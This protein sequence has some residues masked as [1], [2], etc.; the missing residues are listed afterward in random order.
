M[1]PPP[2]LSILVATWNCAPLLQQFL[3]SLAVQ[4]WSDW[5]L[6]LLDNASTDGTAELVAA[7]Q[8]T[9]SEGPQRVVWSSQPD[10]GIYDA[11]NRG[12]QLARGTYLCF[13]GADDT[14][15]DSGSLERIAA[16]TASG[17]DLITA[18]NAYYAPDGRL[19]R[20]WGF[21]W[22]WKRMRQSMNIA[23][24]GML[25]RRALFERFGPFDAS[26]RICGDYEWLL[27]LPPDLRAIHS[28]DP[29]LKVVQA[30][31]SHTRIGRVYAE[32]FR[33]QRRHLSAPV[34]AACWALNWA[35]Y[36]RRRLIGLA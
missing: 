33:A 24:P 5:E 12:L 4:S 6:L 22:Q 35:K 19:L 32:T 10:T 9:L 14:F 25:V 2:R 18:R 21:G 7:F 15:V 11:W 23:H 27:R 1:T 30:G 28:S 8:Q 3:E 34:S 13:I 26:F 36:G 20:H 17:T 29:I 31:V 16:L